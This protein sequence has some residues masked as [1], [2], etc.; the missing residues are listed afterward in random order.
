MYAENG[1][2]YIYSLLTG[3]Q[4]A[5]EGTELTA[6][7][8]YN[9]YFIAGDALAMAAPLSEDNVYE[10]ENDDTVEATL[11][12][13]AKDISAFMMWAAE[14]KLIER[15]QLGFKVMVFL[16]IFSLLLYLTKKQVFVALKPKK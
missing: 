12:Q 16:L 3:Y 5:P 4:D 8:H 14:P 10:Y 13:N 11:D 1:P 2:D 7:T 6:G 15:K 9:P